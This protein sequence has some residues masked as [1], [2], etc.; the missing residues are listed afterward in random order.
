MGYTQLAQVN[1]SAHSSIY[2][3]MRENRSVFAQYNALFVMRFLKRL[4]WER[5][6]LRKENGKSLLIGTVLSF[7]FRVILFSSLSVLWQHL[8]G[9]SS[10]WSM[11]LL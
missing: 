3:H 6:V 8:Q 2:L 7:L 5:Y 10:D 11:G 4:K 9:S 1:E